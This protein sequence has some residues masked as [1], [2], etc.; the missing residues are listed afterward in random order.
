[1][2]ARSAREKILYEKFVKEAIIISMKGAS[3]V[4]KKC[5]KWR[6]QIFT[7][8]SKVQV[9]DKIKSQL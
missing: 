2:P 8:G 6:G 9:F 7:T 3:G 1:M 5:I 4:I